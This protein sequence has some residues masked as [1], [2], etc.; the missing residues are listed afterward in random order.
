MDPA[1]SCFASE[2][3]SASAPRRCVR[4]QSTLAA[5]KLRILV[6]SACQRRKAVTRSHLLERSSGCDPGLALPG[7]AACSTQQYVSGKVHTL[8]SSDTEW[9]ENRLCVFKVLEL[10]TASVIQ[11][12][13][14]R[15]AS[16]QTQ[17]CR[18]ELSDPTYHAPYAPRQTCFRDFYA[19]IGQTAGM[20][21][22]CHLA[23]EP[24]SLKTSLLW[25]DARL[26]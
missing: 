4:L 8:W 15:H 14:V 18:L 21:L 23:A 6:V 17:I 25:L 11:T 19:A 10:A 22:T 16:L 26:H 1:E 7:R 20:R 13:Q 24:A 5:A 12:Q 3:A 2:I 9:I